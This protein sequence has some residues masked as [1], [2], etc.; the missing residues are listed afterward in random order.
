MRAGV[1][2]SPYG[3]LMTGD[4]AHSAKQYEE[5]LRAYTKSLVVWLG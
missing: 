3:K 4:A 5:L 2:T 1:L